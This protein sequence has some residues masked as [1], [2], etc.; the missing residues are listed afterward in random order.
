MT[1]IHDQR[2]PY[3]AGF[4]AGAAAAWHD[5][6]TVA[7]SLAASCFGFGWLVGWLLSTWGRP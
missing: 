7:L 3:E 6:W 4:T 5:L 2:T 1:T